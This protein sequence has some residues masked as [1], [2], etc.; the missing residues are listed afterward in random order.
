[1]I[2]NILDRPIEISE[3]VESA[4]YGAA[5][6]AAGAVSD[7]WTGME[8]E[9]ILAPTAED[10]STEDRLFKRYLRFYVALLP[11]YGDET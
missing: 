3:C 7:Q 5:K 1:M 11:V 2:A 6:L 9:R 4:C 10:V 8:P